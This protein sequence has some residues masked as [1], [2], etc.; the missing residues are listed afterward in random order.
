MT[1]SCSACGGP[2]QTGGQVCP[3]CGSPTSFGAAADAVLSHGSTVNGGR[4]R[5]E[6]IVGQGGFGITYRAYDARLQ[7]TVALKELFPPGCV[8][9]GNSVVPSPKLALNFSDSKRQ[10]VEEARAIARLR[11]R[12]VV[13]VFEVFEDFNTAYLVMEFLAGETY[14]TRVLRSGP[15]STTETIN[16]VRSLAEALSLVHRDGLL[17]RDVKPSNIMCVDGQPVLI[18]FG[19]ARGFTDQ[20]SQD[21]SRLISPGY[22]PLEQYAGRAKF[23]PASDVYS[24]AASGYFLLTGTAPVGPADRLQGDELVPLPAELPGSSLGRALTS[25]L[26]VG[27]SDRPPTMEALLALLDE[28]SVG[29]NS[30]Q[31]RLIDSEDDQSDWSR[32]TDGRVSSKHPDAKNSRQLASTNRR[33]ALIAGAI[34]L[35][36]MAIGAA[37]LFRISPKHTSA[38]SA[39]GPAASSTE[40]TNTST[41]GP[42]AQG[43]EVPTLIGLSI[44]DAQARLTTLGLAARRELAP[45]TSASDGLVLSSRPTHGLRVADGG[46]VV[47][48]V[49]RYEATPDTAPASVP[50][51]D[52]V[53]APAA[54]QTTQMATAAPGGSAGEADLGIAGSVPKPP[55]CDGQWVVVLASS[56]QPAFDRA[57]IAQALTE[58]PGS[59]YFYAPNSCSSFRAVHPSG[60][61]IYAVYFGLY[62]SQA[63][64]CSIRPNTSSYVKRADN[65]TNP[66]KTYRC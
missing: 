60:N 61:K 40:P 62:A 54:N 53:P 31:T 34:V 66:L 9:S 3:T 43:V 1:A 45:S 37:V 42:S 41:S 5:I 58:F 12:S 35:T 11:H 32:S 19:A 55:P 18:D 52:R 14:E 65:T 64:A 63:D 47:L 20:L 49:G 16:V 8:R 38:I 33:P 2:L 26:A 4:Y 10:F 48:T 30:A 36:L 21:L 7:R 50:A 59:S 25:G 17:H 24:L 28:Q 46:V 39:P 44:V 27:V 51:A 29:E 57:Q 13:Q 15:L 6:E 23:G 22:S 56:A